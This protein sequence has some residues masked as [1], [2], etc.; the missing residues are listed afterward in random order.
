MATML[1]AFFESLKYVGHFFPIAFFRIYF[2]YLFVEK[3][4][5]KFYGDYLIQPRL[6]ASISEYL[7]HSDAPQWYI[8][9]ME[10]LVVPNWQFFA[11]SLAYLEVVVGLCVVFGIL[12][13]PMSLLGVVLCLNQIYIS[14]GSQGDYHSLNLL[15]FLTLGW[16]GA[17]RCLGFDYYFFKRH[18]GL[19]W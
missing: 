8:Q 16:L 2:G 9:V 3:G 7:P 1:V 6:A 12:M 14:P 11:Y 10:N 18:R 4:L 19:W 5:D 15:L 17:G 13:R